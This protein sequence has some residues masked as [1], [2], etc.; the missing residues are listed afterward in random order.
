MGN[1]YA[2]HKVLALP[3]HP[4]AIDT[5][6]L[7]DTGIFS[8]SL[9]LP[10]SKCLS[11]HLP[12]SIPFNLVIC[13]RC[14]FEA[15][16]G[17]LASFFWALSETLGL[18]LLCFD[19]S[20]G[21]TFLS[22]CVDCEHV[23]RERSCRITVHDVGLKSVLSTVF[24]CVSQVPCVSF[25]YITPLTSQ[26]SH[27]SHRTWH[28]SQVPRDPHST[29]HPSQR[30]HVSRSTWH[31]HRSLMSLTVPTRHTSQVPGMLHGYFASFT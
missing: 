6:P 10:S 14:S 27:A 2:T 24:P 4:S 23:M 19:P 9:V 30:P 12:N 17:L 25:K 5:L 13:I 22:G 8:V 11:C 29:W 28:S 31:H 16:I 21:W 18:G 3:V 26:V 7:G 1:V 20:M 15:L